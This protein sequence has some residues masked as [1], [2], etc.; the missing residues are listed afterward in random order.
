ML[1]MLQRLLK[2]IQDTPAI[3]FYNIQDLLNKNI[4]QKDVSGGRS[5]NY[6]LKERT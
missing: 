5:T 2:L 3:A 1:W 4:L 6:F